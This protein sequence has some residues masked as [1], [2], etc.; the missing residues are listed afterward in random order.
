MVLLTKGIVVLD[1]QD[2]KL[3]AASPAQ[4][5]R[6]G[7][8]SASARPATF[9][10]RLFPA[11]TPL[12]DDMEDCRRD[13]MYRLPCLAEIFGLLVGLVLFRVALPYYDSLPPLGK[14]ILGLLPYQFFAFGACLL[15]LLPAMHVNGFMK[16]LDMI[17]PLPPAKRLAWSIFK[18]LLVVYPSVLVL[19][20]ISEK[21]CELLSIPLSEQLL[22]MLGGEGGVLF[23]IVSSVTT[24]ILAPVTEEILIRIVLFRAIR[25]IMP[26]WATLLSSL[27]FGAMHCMPQFIPALFLLGLFLQRAR[28]SFGLQGAILLHAFYNLVAFI[29][30]CIQSTL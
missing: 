8:D 19:N 18:M 2:E 21:V 14:L 16:A 10:R 30:I 23:W 12:L 17:R 27:A 20:V 29:F 4:D 22:P 15:A 7:G 9:L 13:R 3:G 25:S 6:T 28:K 24:V 5:G 26:I 11:P 1:S